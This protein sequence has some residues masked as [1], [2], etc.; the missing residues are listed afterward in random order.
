MGLTLVEKARL[1]ENMKKEARALSFILEGV[2]PM[3]F[4]K[5]STSQT[6]K[7]TWE[8]QESSYQGMAKVKT[9]KLLN[10]KK[11]ILRI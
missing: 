7:A 5:I 4:A 3:I 1:D 6:S 8:I 9:I 11:G 10:L 2:Q